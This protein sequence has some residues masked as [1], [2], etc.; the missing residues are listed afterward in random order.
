MSDEILTVDGLE[1]QYSTS[2]GSVQAVD[3]ISFSADRGEVLGVLGPNGAGK[4]TTIKCILGLVLPTAGSISIDGIDPSTEQK[5]AFGRVSAVLEGARNVYWR[6]TVRENLRFF[7]GCQGVHPTEA[8]DRIDRIVS[9]VDLTHKE[10][11][12][13]RN[14]SRGQQQKTSLATALVRD[15]PLLFLDEP[16]LGLDVEASLN[17]RREIRRLA[18]EEN[19]TIVLS[20]HNMKI[21]RELCDRVIIMNDGR[22]VAEDTVENL[23][24]VFQ[25]QAYEITFR[26]GSAPTSELDGFDLTEIDGRGD[27]TVQVVLSG[28]EDLYDLM[29]VCRESG[30]VIER[31]DSQDPDLEEVFL[32]VI[33]DSS[34]ETREPPVEHDS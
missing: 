17:L 9:K 21:V 25:T 34:Q 2:D 5:E 33:E 7:V 16:T 30:A 24:D 11:D 26:D 6:L 13:V 15:T 19:R 31:I 22:V 18:D 29:E 20:S 28:S 3:G 14:L 1:K 12:V 23:V 4:T 10:D 32:D 8:E 27:N